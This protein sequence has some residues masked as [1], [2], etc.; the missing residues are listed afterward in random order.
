M[1]MGEWLAQRGEGNARE[2]VARLGRFRTTFTLSSLAYCAGHWLLTHNFSI[3]M[4]AGG[5]VF[6][7]IA[8]TS[9]AWLAGWFPSGK[10]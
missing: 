10:E 9:I 1:A 4:M 7:A 8:A 5:L 2:W 6:G 3:Y